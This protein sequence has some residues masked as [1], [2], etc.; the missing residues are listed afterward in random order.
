MLI[1]GVFEGLSIGLILPLFDLVSAPENVLSNRWLAPV[2]D[3][4]GQPEHGEFV[5]LIFSGVLVVFA[6]KNMLILGLLY[7]QTRWVWQ[8]AARAMTIL[9]E[10]YMH[11]PYSVYLDR[12]TNEFKRNITVSVS[13]VYQGMIV[14]ILNIVAETIVVLAIVCL[15]F[16]AKPEEAF[17]VAV[18]LIVPSTIFLVVSKPLLISWG[19]IAH[20]LHFKHLSELSHAFGAIKEIK[21][22]NR[23]NSIIE[24][25]EKI[26]FA[27]ADVNQKTIVV[28]G[29]PRL[30]LET[31]IIGSLMIVAATVIWQGQSPSTILPTL[32]LFAAAAFRLLPSA[33]RIVSLLGA[34]NLSVAA[35]R[36]IQKD[37]SIAPDKL[38]KSS[39]VVT[40]RPGLE[41]F[42]LKKIEFRYGGAKST[43]LKKIDLQV[44]QGQS[45]ALIGCSGA[46]KTTLANVILGLLT[47]THGQAIFYR[48][49]SK[50]SSG[51]PRIALVP[52]DTFLI[53][54]TLR[55]NIAFAVPSSEICD[56]R[57]KNAVQMAY[58][59]DFVDGL[60][61][62]LNTIVGERGLNLSGGQKQRVAIARALYDDPDILV[63]DEATSA[64]D[65]RSEAAITR[66]ITGL[67]GRKTLVIIAHR[68]SSVRHCDC[69]YWMENGEITDRGTF[70]ELRERNSQFAKMISL[71]DLS[72]NTK[73][74]KHGH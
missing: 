8:S 15:L 23:E 12:N 32:G 44:N 47:P 28:N 74:D 26:P 50:I 3:F 42:E 4:L 5:V 64:L 9:F 61:D 36:E 72:D 49:E 29:L 45:I 55:D 69:L 2:Y 54:G 10:T 35:V 53:D 52:Q 67:S 1:I 46:G 63:F 27:T 70:E 68:L 48:P 71:L 39:H 34:I 21:V 16:F 7:M 17:I 13:Q 30:L 18:V 65:A 6:I 41:E 22:L 25:Y 24:R 73:L 38:A 40:S 19:N 62:G 20:S 37:L 43:T 14:P 56:A 57:V 58:L 11:M 59:Q 60:P 33:N 66:A 31:L 51:R